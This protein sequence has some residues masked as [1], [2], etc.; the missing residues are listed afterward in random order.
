MIIVTNVLLV[1]GMSNL[2][3]AVNNV[4][5]T[6]TAPL[7]KIAMLRLDSVNAGRE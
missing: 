3:K 1:I 2:E 5:V 7:V 4:I 6:Q